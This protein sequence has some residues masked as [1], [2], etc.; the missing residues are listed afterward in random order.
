MNLEMPVFGTAEYVIRRGA[1]EHLTQIGKSRVALITCPHLRKNNELA[2]IE[3]MFKKANMDYQII[4]DIS[5]EPLI[6]ELE[7]PIRKIQE[8][9][10]DCIVAIGGGSVLDT[11]KALWI[12]YEHPELTWEDAFKY[13]QIP[14][15]G[16]KAQLIAVPTTSGTGSETTFVAVFTDSET[17]QKRLIMSREIIPDIAILDANLLDTLPSSVAAH[18]GLDALVHAMEGAVCVASSPMV[19]SIA[20]ATCLDIFEWLPASAHPERYPEKSGEARERMHIAASMAGMTIAN[21]CCG[22]AHAFDQPGPYFGLQH[23]LVCGIFLPYTTK[24]LL[25]NPIYSLMARRMGFTGSDEELGKQLVRYLNDF[26]KELKIPRSFKAADVDEAVYLKKLDDFVALAEESISTRLSPVIPDK[27][28][29]R[30]IFIDAYY[31][32]PLY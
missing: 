15:L 20:I 6:Q 10:P 3:E 1:L 27:E 31:G 29:I 13:F 12:F 2:K 30:K 28:H 25:P 17:H 24:F 32:N 23:G 7:E 22:L 26:N 9:Q 11:G 16:L 5:H 4:A 21:T 14:K 18:A 19:T 8:Y